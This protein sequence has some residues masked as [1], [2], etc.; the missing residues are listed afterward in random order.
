MNC[1]FKELQE[2]TCF[3]AEEAVRREVK[4]EA[5][6]E[7]GPVAIVGSQPWPI[8]RSRNSFCLFAPVLWSGQE[9]PEQHRSRV[10]PGKGSHRG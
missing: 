8:G 6:I 9:L 3:A 4:E 7:V 1:T 5:G 2:K 10:W